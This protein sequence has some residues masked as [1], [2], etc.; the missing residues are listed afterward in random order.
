MPYPTMQS[1]FPAAS[2]IPTAPRLEAIAA[3]SRASLTGFATELRKS[4]FPWKEP[5]QLNDWHRTPLPA[6][7]LLT[8]DVTR[9]DVQA[10]ASPQARETT[11]KR[12]KTCLIMMKTSSDHPKTQCDTHYC[13]A[14]NAGVQA[15]F[16]LDGRSGGRVQ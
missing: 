12:A 14:V 9:N 11:M 5:A 8:S 1:A 10:A 4:L 6:N 2:W 15:A 3:R 16:T 13:I 7:D